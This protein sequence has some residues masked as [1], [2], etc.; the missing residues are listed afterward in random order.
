MIFLLIRYPVGPLMTIY[1][2]ISAPEN[3]EM[4]AMKATIPAKKPFNFDRL[5]TINTMA[6]ISSAIPPK[7]MYIF[8]MD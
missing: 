5:T 4:Y 3:K 6:K 1:K 7:E 8:N 2:M